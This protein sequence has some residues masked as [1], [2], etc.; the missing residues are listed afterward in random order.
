MAPVAE[1]CQ[2]MLVV[3]L[4]NPRAPSWP[5]SRSAAATGSE[6]GPWGQE[7]NHL[8][9]AAADRVLSRA[10]VSLQFVM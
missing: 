7:P 1:A 3:A 5:C 9:V 6:G 4:G 8:P 10:V 2:S